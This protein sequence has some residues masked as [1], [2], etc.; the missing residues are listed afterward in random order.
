LCDVVNI[1]NKG[2]LLWRGRLKKITKRKPVDVIESLKKSTNPYKRNLIENTLRRTK[3]EFEERGFVVL[4]QHEIVNKLKRTNFPPLDLGN[5]KLGHGL[6]LGFPGCSCVFQ[7]DVN[8]SYHQLQNC[9][10]PSE[11]HF[12]EPQLPKIQTKPEGIKFVLD[13]P[14]EIESRCGD[15]GVKRIRTITLDKSVS[16]RKTETKVISDVRCPH[17]SAQITQKFW[18][19]YDQITK[20][21]KS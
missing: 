17:C 2:F 12:Q 8:G 16:P 5:A 13:I 11:D 20:S 6:L 1:K 19:K 14:H 4:N 3:R 21:T 7:I 9:D 18:L 15:C 10:S